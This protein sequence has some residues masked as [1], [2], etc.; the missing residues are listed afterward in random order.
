MATL[1]ARVRALESR[2]L[3]GDRERLEAE[4]RRLR[5]EIDAAFPG[6]PLDWSTEMVEQALREH[7][8]DQGRFARL[9]AV[10]R[11]LESPA[12]RARRQGE[13]AAMTPEEVERVLAAEVW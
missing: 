8:S 11:A 3:P 7:F 2:R 13:A 4:R 5:A 9:D 12:E 6:S 1:E 10:E